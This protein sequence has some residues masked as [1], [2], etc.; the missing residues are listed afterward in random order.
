MVRLIAAIDEKQGIAD[1]HGIPW[2]GK[3]PG[4]VKYYTDKI[5]DGNP[6]LMGYGVYKEMT[7]PYAGG[8]NYVASL[9]DEKLHDGFELVHN[10]AEFIK[11]S[12]SD[13]WDV[14]GAILF[15]STIELADELYIT[16]L[17]G[18]FG[19]T[20]FFPEFKN[21]FELIKESDPITE[22]NVTYTF[23]VWKRKNHNN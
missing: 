15:A 2:R 12:K 21:E 9:H 1:E 4:D 19:C 20:K 10:A 13:I 3:V 14:G 23:Q 18:D 11:N 16:Q 8:T 6:I 17:Q 22:N 7:K 5:N